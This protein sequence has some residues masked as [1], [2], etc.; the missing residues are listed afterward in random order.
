[1][2]F[3]GERRTMHVVKRAWCMDAYNGLRGT[4]ESAEGAWHIAR[5]VLSEKMELWRVNGDSWLVTE[6]MFGNK[7]LFLWCYEGRLLMQLIDHL[8]LVCHKAGFEQ[9]SF[10][11]RHRGALRILRRYGVFS[12]PTKTAGECQYVIDI[13]IAM[14]N[15][16]T[17]KELS[18]VIE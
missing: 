5:G 12:L 3:I 7:M 17:P 8:V 9:L 4:F 10:F 2:N 15:R 6:V 14:R 11:T 1:M 13:D 18:Y 16:I